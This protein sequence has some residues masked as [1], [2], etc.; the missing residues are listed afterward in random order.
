MKNH[1]FLALFVS[2]LTLVSFTA[3][4]GGSSGSSGSGGGTT[5]PTP[6]VTSISPTTVAAGA[7]ATTLTVNG[8]GFIAATSIQVGGLSESTTYVSSSQVTAIVPASQLAS[9][10]QLS[11]V[12]VNGSLSSGTGSANLQVTNP[13]PAITSLSPLSVAA[14][15]APPVVTVS[16][17]GFVPTT[18]IQV[19]GSA[20][21]TTYVNATQV[22]VAL[23][24]TD[25]STAGTLSL[26][27][28]N[29][30]PGGGTS[31]ASTIAVSDPTPTLTGLSPV[32]VVTGSSANTI[33]LNGTGF[34]PASSVLVNGSAVS[35]IFVSST[36]LTLTLTGLTT[37]STLSIAVANPA[38]GGGTSAARTF[39]V[40][41]PTSAPVITQATPT[42]FTVG[43]TASSITVD[44][45]NFLEQVGPSTYFITGT[46]LGDGTP[47]QTTG[48][49]S[50]AYQFLVGQVPSSLLTAT[51]TATIT[52]STN[53]TPALSN[54]V[55]VNIV[56][57]PPPTLTAIYPSGGPINTPSSL[58]LDGTGFT[59]SSTVAVNGVNVPSTYVGT[60]E[61]TAT[62]PASATLLPGN[63]NITVTTPAPGGGTTA[64]QVYTTFIS[65]ANND[66]VYN[67]ADGL[68][69]AS[70]PATA[71][72]VLGN[73]VV[74]IDPY[75]GTIARQIQ[76]GTTPNKLALSTDGTQLFVGIDGAGA[77][78][79]INLATGKVVNQF[80]LGGGPGMYNA[81][82]TAAYLA[83]VPGL[84]NS[85]AVATTGQY[86]NGSSVAI[87]DSGVA[88][89]GGSISVG[90]GP[91]S[92]GSSAS[93]LY[94]GS[95]YVYALTVG[96]TGITSSTKLTSTSEKSYVDPVRQ[97]CALPF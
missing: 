2:S 62:L 5:T 60:T 21:T 18:T 45:S 85:V 12:A 64:P 28:V 31:A 83:A 68:L 72:G 48:G 19:N 69:Y 29:A 50:G 17:T 95:S 9:G 41:T 76:V 32:Y 86:S 63:L 46:I 20:R 93:T 16:G 25:V 88:R 91:L 73:A 77:V 30:S 66:I 26:T 75:T 92:F 70:V 4:S 10:A 8:S 67:S 51:G 78:A 11:V 7:A 24:T 33:T 44:G 87:F 38:P 90:E 97:W 14:G 61:L 23:T 22:S 71:P 74:G 96:S 65:I 59:T 40:L 15:A 53:A 57:P 89:T 13:T 42:Q 56:N 80:A 34:V 3:C 55:T 43:S 36:Q 79:Q 1:H 84:P 54:A 37:A 27:A 49:I 39:F 58:T 81:P 94:V 52:G 6:A 82:Y 47:L 35:P